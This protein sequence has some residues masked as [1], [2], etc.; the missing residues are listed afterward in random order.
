MRKSIVE[1]KGS[2]DKKLRLQPIP[3]NAF[4]VPTSLE[5]DFFKWWCIFIRPFVKI[6]D[7]EADIIAA[8]LKQRYRLSKVISDPAVLDSQLMSSESKK[9]ILEEC[10]INLQH[11][12]V[13]MG[14]F[15]KR[16]IITE[17]GIN[18]KLIPNIRE[19]DDGTFRLLV[20]FVD[21][22]K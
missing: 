22:S 10:G 17:N 7:R 16:K 5:G 14:K 11:F 20:R 15:R 18:S 8:M 19:N 2:E 3:N 13:V 9:K 21:E 6:T 12:Y 4:N 1:Y